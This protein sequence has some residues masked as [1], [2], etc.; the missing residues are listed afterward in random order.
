ML[1]S[2]T[3][4]CDLYSYALVFKSVSSYLLRP[5]SSTTVSCLLVTGFYHVSPLS[6]KRIKYGRK[7][8]ERKKG[9][10]IVASRT[11]VRHHSI[12]IRKEDVVT[13]QYYL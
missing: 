13:R 4:S 11:F 7:N 12:T 8:I 6:L 3:T 5:L 10:V 9:E 2:E 1:T